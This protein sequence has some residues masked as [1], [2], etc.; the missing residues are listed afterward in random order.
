[1]FVFH[2]VHGEPD[3]SAQR[4]CSTACKE[5][6]RDHRISFGRPLKL[7]GTRCIRLR[8][9][10]VMSRRSE[11]PECAGDTEQQETRAGEYP[12]P[13]AHLPSRGGLWRGTTIVFVALTLQRFDLRDLALEHEN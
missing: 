3:E 7:L 2:D 5:D 1:A 10:L 11:R 12:W 13:E 8:H 4:G 9:C 6:V